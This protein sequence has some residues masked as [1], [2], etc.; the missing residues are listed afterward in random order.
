MIIFGPAGI[1]GVKEAIFN[2]ESF[3]K[4]G[5]K[6]CEIAF[7]YGIYIKNDK[8]ALE[9]GKKARELGIKL[10]IHAPYWLNLNSEDKEKIEASKKRILDCCKIGEIMGAEIVVF[11]A[12]FYSKMSK[13]ETFQNIKRVVLEI[14]SEI[15]KNNWKIK[16]AP[17]TMGKINVFGSADEILRLVQ[18]TGC[19]FC[20]DFAHLWAREQGK[21]SY[22]EIYNKFKNFSSIHAHFSGIDFSDKGE[23]SHKPTPEKEIEKLL[24]SLPRPQ[25]S[26][27]ENF[28]AQKIHKRFS[29][30]KDITIINEAPNPIQDAEKMLKIWEKS[31]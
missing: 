14:L 5:L 16:I 28:G 7:T 9:I 26:L 19:S 12:G 24:S 27:E 25:N 4:L 15:K 21:I 23:R 6:A 10:S 30:N 11:H 3:H 8:D 31:S 20:L 18:E 22:S 17:E 29:W 2:L 13:E 1:G